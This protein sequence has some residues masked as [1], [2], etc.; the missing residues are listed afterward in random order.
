MDHRRWALMAVG[1]C[2]LVG[3]AVGCA[4]P[5]G[6]AA[7]RPPA[8]AA[9]EA[10]ATKPGGKHDAGSLAKKSQN[11]VSDLISVPF[12]FNFNGNVGPDDNTQT[13]LN[14]QPVWPFHLN[15]DWNLITRTIIPVIDQPEMIPGMDSTF[16]LGDINMSLFLSP[17]KPG[18]V[19]WGVG[20]AISFPTATD[21]VLGTDQWSV[22]P[23]F[24]AL[25]MDGPW[26]FGRLANHIWSVAGND[27]VDVSTT[28]IQPFVNYNMAGGFR[29]Y[30][31][32]RPP[33]PS[34][35]T[36]ADGIMP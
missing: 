1:V 16:G 33:S 10:G 14:I 26:V 31:R 20:P 2:V 17:A 25:T 4:V 6:T 27:R 8:Q 21:D 7:L 5:G 28:T 9:A 29:C 3:M 30:L 22:G 19:I 23:S 18:K 36:L 24:V 35:N 11:P 34:A 12:Q 32:A 15:E 13:V